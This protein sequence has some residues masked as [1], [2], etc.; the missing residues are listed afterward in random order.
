[1][2][3]FDQN[4]H[5]YLEALKAKDSLRRLTTG[6][7]DGAAVIKRDGRKLI[8]FS[9]NNYLG[10]ANHP[11]LIE[12]ANAWTEEWGTGA[13]A[14]RL[15]TG[16]FDIH[17][18]IEDKLA[19]FKQTE[20][21]LIFN[22]GYQANASVIP[23]LLDKDVLGSTPLVFTDKLVHA[24]IH[25]GCKAAGVREIRYRHN[26]YNHLESLFKKHHDKSG[27]R[28]VLTESVFSMDG[29]CA[30]L[31]A[32]TELAEKYDAFLYI[33]EA[34]ATGVLGPKGAGLSATMPGKIDCVMGTFSKALGSFGAY[35]ACSAK[36]KEYLVNCCGGLIYATALPPGVLGAMDA[37]LDLVPTMDRE[38]LQLQENAQR[39]RQRLNDYQIST[40]SSTTQIVP[41]VIGSTEATLEA[42][43]LLEEAGILG[44]AIRPPTVPKGSSRIR[45]AV[46]SA[47]DDMHIKTLLGVVP[48]LASFQA[49]A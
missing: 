27:T 17:E 8:N 29:D 30:D 15:V 31:N 14:S 1:M 19:F 46:S 36:L 34:H 28:F 16:T 18:A 6:R 22:S 13:G 23:A 24:S 3:S 41:A 49:G 5:A 35:V 12:R 38:R 20:A 10:L 2:P 7:P 40:A 47:H 11:A 33:D 43:Q 4:W 9:S 48:D 37:A 21:A 32:L 39:L 42:S 25:H 45:F 26:D 44:V